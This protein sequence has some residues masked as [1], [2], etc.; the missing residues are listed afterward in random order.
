MF[1]SSSL[2]SITHY[3]YNNLKFGSILVKEEYPQR[4]VVECG[5]NVCTVW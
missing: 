2:K 1:F 4:E 3:E 5:M